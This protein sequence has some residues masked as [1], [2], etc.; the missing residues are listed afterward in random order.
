MALAL[1][2]IDGAAIAFAATII[3]L[4]LWTMFNP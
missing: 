2:I 4:C 1:D 3:T